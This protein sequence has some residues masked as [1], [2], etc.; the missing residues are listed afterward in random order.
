MA[1]DILVGDTPKARKRRGRL[2]G[3]TPHG[4]LWKH[5]TLADIEGLPGTEDLSA[6][7]LVTLVRN[8][9]DRLVSYYAWA[10]VQ[11]FD[12]PVIAAAKAKEFQE[13]LMDPSVS[14]ALHAWPA[15][16]Y[17]TDAGGTERGALFARLEALTSDLEPLWD[18]LGFTL[19]VPRLNA[20]DRDP[21]YRS[22]YDQHSADHVAR[23]LQ[24]DISRF[25][26]RF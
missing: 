6:V 16:R 21:D 15:R 7:F 19:D 1:E 3:L 26:Y 22:Y 5:S 24:D 18:H 25:D 13:F 20:S 17:M 14:N 11:Q 23:L 10:R 2:K 9:W 4:R 8:P 12:H